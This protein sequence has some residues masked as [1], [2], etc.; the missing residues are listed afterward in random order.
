METIVRNLDLMNK[1]RSKAFTIAGVTDQ[2]ESY[3]ES[4]RNIAKEVLK[5][6]AL[7][8]QKKYLHTCKTPHTDINKRKLLSED[9]EHFHQISINNLNENAP[10]ILK[11]EQSRRKIVYNTLEEQKESEKIENLTILELKTNI[12]NLLEKFCNKNTWMEL[13]KNEVTGKTKLAYIEFLSL[14]NEIVEDIDTT[15]DID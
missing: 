13:Y 11:Q 4:Q 15:T 3:F 6:R 8:R 12:L 9:L 10:K 14:S 7:I 5:I 2:K 1:L